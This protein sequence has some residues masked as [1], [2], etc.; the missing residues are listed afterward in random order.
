M[1][2]ER[3]AKKVVQASGVEDLYFGV[4]SGRIFGLDIVSLSRRSGS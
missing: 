1:A 2:L 4:Q 3:F